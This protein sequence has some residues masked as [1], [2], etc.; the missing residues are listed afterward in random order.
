MN[1]TYRCLLLWNVH[2]IAGEPPIYVGEFLYFFKFNKLA[3]DDVT[4][5]Q[6]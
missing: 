2:T 1:S 3:F 6:L 4:F 5:C